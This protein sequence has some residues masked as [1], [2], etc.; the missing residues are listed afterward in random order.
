[1]SGNY[2][3]ACRHRVVPGR[4][5]IM[6]ETPLGSNFSIEATSFPCCRSTFPSILFN[7]PPP[8]PL[9]STNRTYAF[10]FLFA[11][12]FSSHAVL[13]RL[14]L[15]VRA[16]WSLKPPTHL[17]LILIRPLIRLPLTRPNQP[18]LWPFFKGIIPWV[19]MWPSPPT[20]I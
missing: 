8:D 4:A 18:C 17:P 13:L 2:S 19:P 7:T 14:H 11:P 12:S 5:L 6:R 10:Y 20:T 9:T 16:S 15:L 3:Q 1:M